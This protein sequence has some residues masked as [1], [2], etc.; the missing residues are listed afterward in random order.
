MELVRTE[1]AVVILESRDKDRPAQVR[2]PADAIILATGYES[3]TLLPYIT[4][5]GRNRIDLHMHWSNRG[6]VQAYLGLAVDNFPNLFFLNGPNTSS[7][8][9]S[10]LITIEN[11]LHYALKR[12]KPIL[13]DEISSW[14]V[15]EEACKRWTDQVQ[16]ASKAGVWVSG[17]CTS[18][19]VNGKGWNAMVYP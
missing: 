17:G 13:T 19:Y 11:A 2:L 9:T 14:E 18:W 3:D 6:G 10:I 5:K 15:S 1:E 4:V 16:R 7:S 12:I 8:H